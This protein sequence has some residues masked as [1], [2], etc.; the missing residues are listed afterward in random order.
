[1]NTLGC[2]PFDNTIKPCGRCPGDTREF[3]DKQND[4]LEK[5]F[6]LFKKAEIKQFEETK[7][8]E[9]KIKSLENKLKND[10]NELIF[11]KEKISAD[12]REHRKRIQELLDFNEDQQVKRKKFDQSLNQNRKSFEF[13]LFK[14]K[15]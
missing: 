6:E 1:M 2:K 11:L 10:E 5:N 8:F 14:Q 9:N 4:F 13:N 3:F 7:C 15:K 12:D